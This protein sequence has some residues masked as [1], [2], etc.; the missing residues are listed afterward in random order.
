MKLFRIQL[1]SA[2]FL[3]AVPF[4]A[5]FA[6]ESNS[7]VACHAKL[8]HDSFVGENFLKWQ[9]SVHSEAGI[10][11]DRCHGGNPTKMTRQEAHLGVYNSSNPKSKVYYKNVPRTCGNCHREEYRAF[12]SSL[13]YEELER[14]G[15]GPTCVSC[16]GSKA[17]K[18]IAPDEISAVCTRC[19]NPRKG[20][21]PEIPTV[22][23]NALYLMQVA[24]DYID[25]ANEFYRLSH[26]SAAKKKAKVYLDRAEKVYREAT[27]SWHTFDVAHVLSQL[28]EAIANARK[29]KNALDK[30]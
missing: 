27:S 29:A 25:W 11:C 9:H 28:H 8:P 3:L 30:G 21:K 14:R 24:G 17:A 22:A 4:Y 5:V 26:S 6:Q 23:A 18:I 12:Q 16:H 7:C 20:I 19:H 15:N 10:T 2:L 13:H 1:I